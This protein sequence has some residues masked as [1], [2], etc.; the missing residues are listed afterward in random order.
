MRRVARGIACSHRVGAGKAL[1]ALPS[2]DD[3][4]GEKAG[5]D[6]DTLGYGAWQNIDVSAMTKA[7]DSPEVQAAHFGPDWARLQVL[8]ATAA[9]KT[10]GGKIAERPPEE[11]EQ[12]APDVVNPSLS[13]KWT[14]DRLASMPR[15]YADFARTNLPPDMRGDEVQ[16]DDTAAVAAADDAAESDPDFV[17]APDV[18]MSLRTDT[19]WDPR[20]NQPAQGAETQT[21]AATSDVASSVQVDE[22]SPEDPLQWETED[23]VAWL[24]RYADIDDHVAEAFRMVRVDGDMLLN[25]VMPCTLFKEMRKWHNRGRSDSPRVSELLVQ[26][27]IYLCYPYGQ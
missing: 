2:P 25:K 19:Q 6:N 13:A 27:T 23:V 4:F 17:P 14:D 22:L 18:P 15:T 8:A 21:A 20:L 12:A 5:W 26:E 16:P 11:S 24:Q 3:P 7:M 10:R 1:K 9:A